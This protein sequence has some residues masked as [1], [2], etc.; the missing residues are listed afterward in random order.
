MRDEGTDQ[1]FAASPVA[2]GANQPAFSGTG[3][4]TRDDVGV[5]RRPAAL[6]SLW[7]SA[8][9]RREWRSRVEH[10]EQRWVGRVVSLLGCG[11]FVE[12]LGHAE[13]PELI[14]LIEG[15]WVSM[16]SPQW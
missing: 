4:A 1:L 6:G 16:W 7:N 9:S 15:G 12:C 2:K 13:Q 5:G 8:R 11:D 14:E 3:Q 10:A